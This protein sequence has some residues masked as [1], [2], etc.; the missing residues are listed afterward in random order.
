[1]ENNIKGYEILLE[2]EIV[3]RE[4]IISQ[5]D[6]AY[7]NFNW[8]ERN[9]PL[10]QDKDSFC[11][12]CKKGNKNNSIP[13]K[14]EFQ[15]EYYVDKGWDKENAITTHGLYFLLFTDL[16]D[17][18]ILDLNNK[19]KINGEPIKVFNKL[20]KNKIDNLCVNLKTIY[21]IRNKIAHS[22]LIS[23][24][25]LS[26]LETL[27]E[28][29]KLFFENY[30]NLLSRPERRNSA[31]P[32][33]KNCISTLARKI[34]NLEEDMVNEIEIYYRIANLYPN[35]NFNFQEFEKLLT[36]YVS[37]NKQIGS[38]TRIKELVKNNSKYLT[39]LQ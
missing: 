35:Y 21:P 32:E 22:C 38:I 28:F 23:D 37:L 18:F 4:Y 26:V 17:F 36:S 12:L 33:L 19:F 2:I 34:L 10:G 1:M 15:R 25:E 14:V 6:I 7:K 24:L 16:P 29:L 8:L 5:F 31:I 39:N 9:G 30:D 27:K 13:Q 11:D 20:N 3:L